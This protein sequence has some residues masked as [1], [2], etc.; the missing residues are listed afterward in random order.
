M[1]KSV[2]S[3]DHRDALEA[4]PPVADEIEEPLGICVLYIGFCFSFGLFVFPL[5]LLP[6]LLFS[7]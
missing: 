6:C 4:A 5:S 3:L 1:N 7:V 2:L